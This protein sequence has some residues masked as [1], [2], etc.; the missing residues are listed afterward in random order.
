[1]FRDTAW[2]VAC[3]YLAYTYLDTSVPPLLSLDFV[4]WTVGWNMYAFWMGTILTGHWVLAH[5]V[6]NVRGPPKEKERA[7]TIN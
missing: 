6:R 3:A 5:E 2:A 4:A 7:S 1:M